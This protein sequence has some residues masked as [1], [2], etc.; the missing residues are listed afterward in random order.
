MDRHIARN[1]TKAV[2]LFSIT[3]S[4]H[5]KLFRIMFVYSTLLLKTVSK[6]S[7]KTGFFD[8][9]MLIITQFKNQILTQLLHFSGQSDGGEW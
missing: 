4:T 8:M 2:M 9:K 3:F 7:R 6:K 5:F 1:I